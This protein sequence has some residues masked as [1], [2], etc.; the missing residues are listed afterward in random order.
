M[1]IPRLIAARQALFLEAYVRYGNITQA[2]KSLGLNRSQHY[3]WSHDP[4]Y[5][6]AFRRAHQQAVNALR[7]A[8]R[9]QAAGAISAVGGGTAAEAQ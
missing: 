9:L 3:Y 4:S 7:D 2:A 8:V 6:T 5:K 1:R